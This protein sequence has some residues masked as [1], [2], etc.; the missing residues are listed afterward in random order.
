MGV[1]QLSSWVSTWDGWWCQRCG[2]I[3]KKGATVHWCEGFERAVH[4]LR[5]CDRCY[6]AIVQ[7]ELNLETP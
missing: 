1:T 5:L 2:K 7:Q 3:G 4:P 6:A